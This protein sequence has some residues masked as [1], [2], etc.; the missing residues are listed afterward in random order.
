MTSPGEP[1]PKP[2][3]IMERVEEM[4]RARRSMQPDRWGGIVPTL[5]LFALIVFLLQEDGRC[6]SGRRFTCIFEQKPIGSFDPDA[7]LDIR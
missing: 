7:S 2:S 4:R 5:L 3:R 6:E 1:P